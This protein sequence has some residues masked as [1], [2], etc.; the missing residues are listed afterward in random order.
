MAGVLGLQCQRRGRWRL[1]GGRP[2]VP[3]LV[4]HSGVRTGFRSSPLRSHVRHHL[5]AMSFRVQSISLVPRLGVENSSEDATSFEVTLKVDTPPPPTIILC[6][7]T[8]PNSRV[9]LYWYGI[10]YS[11]LKKTPKVTR[12]FSRR[13]DYMLFSASPASAILVSRAL[14]KAS[15]MR[16]F[17]ST[18]LSC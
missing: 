2:E 9:R 6:L 17:L 12:Q 13:K 15:F 11:S 7:Q 16:G 14:K 1:C 10:S 5:T 3:A 18:V 8:Q 4:L